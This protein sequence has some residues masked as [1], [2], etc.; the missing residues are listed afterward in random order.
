MLLNETDGGPI[1]M[2]YGTDRDVDG[3]ERYW[4]IAIPARPE[5]LL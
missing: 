5:A 3:S 1:A 2:F 4:N